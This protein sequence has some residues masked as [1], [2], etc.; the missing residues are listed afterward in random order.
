[1]VIFLQ[2]AEA[3]HWLSGPEVGNV[4]RS[5]IMPLISSASLDAS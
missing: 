3:W 2:R 1:M 5:E 4:L